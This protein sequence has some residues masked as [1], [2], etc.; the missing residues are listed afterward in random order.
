MTRRLS[1]VFII[2]VSASLLMEAG[3]PRPR[4]LL[5]WNA[6]GSVAIG[7]YWIQ[8]VRQWSINEIVVV[9]P[10]DVLAG[11]LA[12]E[13]YLP[14]GVPMLKHISALPGQAVCRRNNVILIDDVEAGL[15]QASDRHRR[16]LPD[17]QGCRTIGND[18]L[19][20][21]NRQSESSLDGRYFGPTAT[22]DV[23]GRAI[24]LWTRQPR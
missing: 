22:S 18:E 14:R 12:D 11:W 16:K 20:L 5:I 13:G 19:F 24:P 3:L 2:L 21:M 6:S 7:L 15:A 23:V 10:Q 4:P 17:W 1:S 9:Q 8:P